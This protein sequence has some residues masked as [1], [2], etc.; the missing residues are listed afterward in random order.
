MIPGLW[1]SEGGQSA[2]GALIDHVVFSHAQG[3][4]MRAEAEAGGRTVYEALNDRLAALA[5]AEGVAHPGALTADLHVEPDFHGNRSPRADST[6]RG[7]VAGL[8]L[9]DTADDLA[10]LYSRLCRRS[11]TERAISSRR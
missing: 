2:T 8:S 3:Q 6:L 1:L 11:P 7:I 9:S 5:T 4:A 10:R